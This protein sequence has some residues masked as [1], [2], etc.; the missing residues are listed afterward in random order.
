MFDEDNKDDDL[1]YVISD[2]NGFIDS[3]RQIIFGAFGEQFD[4]TN[5][6]DIDLLINSM[7]E[8]D[9]EEL[10]KTL[11]RDECLSMLHDIVQPRKTKRGKTKYVI[12]ENQFNEIIEAFNARL[13]SNLL[14]GLV[15]EGKVESAYDAEENDFIFWVKDNDKDQ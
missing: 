5:E 9:K 14:T 10:D 4:E 15:N 12:S 13:V 6:T 3:T 11:S 1:V 8:S 2:I 7:T